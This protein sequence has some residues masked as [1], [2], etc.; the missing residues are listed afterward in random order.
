M[1]TETTTERLTIDDMH[2]QGSGYYHGDNPDW[3]VVATKTRDANIL[4][5]ANWDA[6]LQALD[7][8]DYEIESSS[9]WACGWI[10]YLIVKPDSEAL[11]IA[12]DIHEQLADYPVVDDELLS[13]YEFNATDSLWR[14]LSMCE[15]IQYLHKKGDSI[16]AARCDGAHELYDAAESTYYYIELLATE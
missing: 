9:H 16:F 8:T 12:D 7:G 15:R 10:E 1:T 13:Q 5:L 6:F 2:K 4:T 11:R 3:F 14:E